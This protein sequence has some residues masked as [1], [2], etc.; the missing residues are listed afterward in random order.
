MAG[1]L[2]VVAVNAA[3]S[4]SIIKDGNNGILVKEDKFIFAQ[5]VIDI[6]RDTETY[7]CLKKNV[8]NDVKELSIEKMTDKLINSYQQIMENKKDKFTA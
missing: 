7:E 1:G 5:A 2:P 4:T 3:G 6:I 8:C